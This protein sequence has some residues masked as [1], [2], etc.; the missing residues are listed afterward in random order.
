MFLMCWFE[1]GDSGYANYEFRKNIEELKDYAE[2][3]EAERADETDDVE[4]PKDAWST[5]SGNYNY[6]LRGDFNRGEEFTTYFIFS[7]PNDAATFL[8]YWHAYDG[9]DFS[10]ETPGSFYEAA[11]KM[12]AAYSEMLKEFNANEEEGGCSL[13]D[14][15]AHFD[16]GNEI[17]YWHIITTKPVTRSWKVY[18][19]EGH[20]QRESFHDSALRHFSN[21]K[22][23]TRILQIDNADIT[24]TNEY[25]ILTIVRDNARLC[26]EELEGQLS[27]GIFENS[28]TGKVE[29]IIPPKAELSLS[30]IEPEP[31]YMNLEHYQSKVRE[32][33][34]HTDAY[35]KK[36]IIIN[37]TS[38]YPADEYTEETAVQDYKTKKG[39]V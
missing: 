3:H 32:I 30:L 19:E 31:F 9:V 4:I 23:G 28:R 2:L 7:V 17:H 33:G 8:L 12:R 25:T 18:G 10:V 1:D 6:I 34:H 16:D 39:I 15:E 24:G 27:D 21:L 13:R 22:D 35:G 11:E 5:E 29:E 26:V 38:W 37:Q 20:R 14:D 36:Y